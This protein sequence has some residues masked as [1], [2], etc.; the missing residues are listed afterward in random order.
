[1]HEKYSKLKGMYLVDDLFV[2]KSEHQSRFNKLGLMHSP[3][4]GEQHSST[5]MA[6]QVTM[7]LLHQLSGTPKSRASIPTRNPSTA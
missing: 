1:M 2:S 7:D 3:A 5:F 6:T 4:P